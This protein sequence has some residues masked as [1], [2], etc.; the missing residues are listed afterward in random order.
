MF[1]SVRLQQFRSHS[2]SQYE[3]DNGVTIIIG[4]NGSGKTSIVEALYMASTGETFRNSDMSVIT[5]GKD[6][7]RVD[8]VT[9]HNDQ[10][11]IKLQ[12]QNEVLKKSYVFDGVEKQRFLQQYE[13]P[14]VLFEPQDM[15]ILVGDPS[16]RRDAIDRVLCVTMPHYR[17]HSKNYRRALAQRNAIL[18]QMSG[19]N[20]QDIF[21]WDVRLSEL[22]GVLHTARKQLINLFAQQFNDTYSAISGKQQNVTITYESDET[23]ADYTASLL[24]RLQHN[25]AKDVVRG[26][27]SY[28]PHRDDIGVYVNGIL[29]KTAA[30]RGETRTLMLV[31]KMLE[32]S[33]VEQATGQKP[34]L[35]LD[36]VF[37]ELDGSR[38]RLLADAT[39]GYQTII[40][41]TEADVVID[42]FAGRHSVIAL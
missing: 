34:L 7:S 36:D 14:V 33:A 32:L 40:T 39:N 8:T 3:F 1:T 12:L 41:T 19:G 31:L 21:V 6:W 5:T 29:A 28:G 22:G 15:N 37:S 13:L 23:G 24:A 18:K 38:R 26:F 27:T 11:S 4:P 9:E 16:Q 30:S 2:D 20:Q 35:L 42:H 10:R 17:A 25:I